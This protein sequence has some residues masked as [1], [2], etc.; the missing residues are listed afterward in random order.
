VR[1]TDLDG[2]RTYEETYD[3]LIL[4]PGAAPLVPPI[5]GVDHPAVLT[6]R[7]LGDVDRIKAAVDAA[8]GRGTQAPPRVVVVGA[9]FIGLELAEH[10]VQR[11][12][13]TTVVELQDQVLPPLDREMTTPIVA[14]LRSHGVGLRLGDSAAAVTPVPGSGGVTVRL[15]SGA[16][17]VA[18]LVILGVGVRPENRLAVEAGLEV[19]PRGGI[20]VD[21]RMQTSRARGARRSW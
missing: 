2:G 10:L 1:I 20:R 19:G 18:D 16:E 3:R 11:G 7:T 12:A 4:A 15:A 17:V 8:A 5:P 14:T 13:E 6:L 21:E 9:G